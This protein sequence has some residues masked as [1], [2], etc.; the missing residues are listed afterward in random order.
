[1]RT[2]PTWGRADA[3]P[4]LFLTQVHLSAEQIVGMGMQGGLTQS[5]LAPA[6]TIAAKGPDGFADAFD[7][8]YRRAYQHAFKLLGD[9]YDAEDL[10]QEACA[11][12]CLRWER[13]ETPEAWVVTVVT[14]LAFDRFRRAR[15]A[16]KH[17]LS[18]ARES[19]PTD[20]RHIDLQRA[21]A[22]LPK[23]QREA[24]ALRYLAD[25]SEAQTAAA[26]GCAV[27]TV[28]AHSARGIQ[29]LREMLELEDFMEA[30]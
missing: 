18:S 15:L 25:F 10:A 22:K 17:A 28:K 13:L 24:V 23:R 2:T 9:R 27:G 8:L 7:S 20:T 16:A 26:L 12:A 11:R 30:S 21:L 4:Q 29:A 6:P 1:M 14:N 19:D 5:D 3:R